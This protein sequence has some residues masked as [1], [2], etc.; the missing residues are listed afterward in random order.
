MQCFV[1]VDVQSPMLGFLVPASC[2]RAIGSTRP[3]LHTMPTEEPIWG[4]GSAIWRSQSGS[5][6]AAQDCEPLWL[7]APNGTRFRFLGAREVAKGAVAAEAALAPPDAVGAAPPCMA[8]PCLL[9]ESIAVKASGL[10]CLQC[11]MNRQLAR[12]RCTFSSGC[13]ESSLTCST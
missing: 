13:C 3:L 8:L 12:A 5:H 4:L 6:I 9:L 2:V 7:T 11:Y 10:A 1:E